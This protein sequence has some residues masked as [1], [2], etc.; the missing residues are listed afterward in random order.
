M[1]HTL[2]PL[3]RMMRSHVGGFRGWL[4]LFYIWGAQWMLNGTAKW[5]AGWKLPDWFQPATALTAAIASIVILLASGIRSSGDN[6]PPGFRLAS[7]FAVVPFGIGTGSL[8]LLEYVHAVD[9]FFMDLFRTLL[10]SFIMACLGVLLGLELM[11]L[12]IW[13]FLISMITCV[14]YLGY[15]PMVLE[16]MG[17]LG[18]LA[19][20]LIL[21]RW[22]R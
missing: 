1:L 2:S 15:A 7:L 20:G 12:G 8:V 16:F 6:L 19:C 18:L 17:G 3:H 10:L 9:P 4:P 13:M 21:S 22:T 11:I 5:Y 14:W